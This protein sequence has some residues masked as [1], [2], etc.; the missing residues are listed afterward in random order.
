MYECLSTGTSPRRLHVRT[1]RGGLVDGGIRSASHLQGAERRGVAPAPAPAAVESPRT[2]PVIAAPAPTQPGTSPARRC[3]RIHVHVAGTQ[4]S[5]YTGSDATLAS[6]VPAAWILPWHGALL[7]HGVRSGTGR[8]QVRRSF[9]STGGSAR[10]SCECR[11]WREERS[12]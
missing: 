4:R 2:E 5:P 10:T 6:N 1:R 9:S 12:R 7:L 11:S 3:C 8:R